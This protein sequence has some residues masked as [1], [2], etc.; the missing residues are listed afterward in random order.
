MSDSD[1]G[2]GSTGD[3]RYTNL[4]SCRRM[5]FNEHV[6]VVDNIRYF[7]IATVVNN[8]GWI[9]RRGGS[10]RYVGVDDGVV[11]TVGSS[12]DGFRVGVVI[13]TCG[14]AI[15]LDTRGNYTV[16]D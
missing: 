4:T 8:Y 10:R 14:N 9:D 2:I 12:R 1:G 3:V 11:G 6:G 16:A 13:W 15:R 5:V 7:A